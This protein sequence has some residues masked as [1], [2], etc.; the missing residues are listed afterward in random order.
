MVSSN[1]FDFYTTHQNIIARGQRYV[2]IH[3]LLVGGPSLYLMRKWFD[4]QRPRCSN[5]PNTASSVFEFV[6]TC[7]KWQVQTKCFYQ[8]SAFKW[9]NCPA[10][11]SCLRRFPAAVRLTGWK[12]WTS[13]Y[14]PFLWIDSNYPKDP[15][16]Q[17]VNDQ[18]SSWSLFVSHVLKKT[19]PLQGKYAQ[20]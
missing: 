5:H 12:T 20:Q 17:R 2:Q 15:R 18:L 9:R 11:S 19:L 10:W 14:P 16:A 3:L 13:C 7:D 6:E 4:F 1:Q 8:V